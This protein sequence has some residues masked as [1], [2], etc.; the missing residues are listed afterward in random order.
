MV[1]LQILSVGAVALLECVHSCPALQSVNFWDCNMADPVEPVA[2][3]VMGLR[4]RGKSGGGG[5]KS[6]NGGK[7][8]LSL[9]HI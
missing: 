9:I 3:P 5:K 6:K 1:G 7:K 2:V 8:K 4:R